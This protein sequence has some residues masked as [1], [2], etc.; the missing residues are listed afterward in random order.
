M[1]TDEGSSAKPAPDQTDFDAT[2]RRALRECDGRASPGFNQRVLARLGRDRRPTPW[3]PSLVA[4]ATALGV[5]LLLVVA[6][7]PADRPGDDAAG[8]AQRERLLREYE[9]LEAE[10][11]ELR[12][13]ASENSPAL[14]LGGDETFD[15][16]YDLSALPEAGGARPAAL[17]DRG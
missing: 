16:M 3:V 6:S 10:L 12:R 2:L 15:V 5:A 9:A 17:P 7:T 8:T 1:R 4:G 13:L 11:E 14:Y